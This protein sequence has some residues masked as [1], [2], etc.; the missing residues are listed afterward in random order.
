M[1]Y[2]LDVNI[3]NENYIPEKT[4]SNPNQKIYR[5]DL[6]VSNTKIYASYNSLYNHKKICHGVNRKSS[7]Y[8]AAIKPLKIDDKNVNFEDITTI[9]EDL[10]TFMCKP[11]GKYF[12][13][14]KNLRRHL[15]GVHDLEQFGTISEKSIQCEFC[16]MAFVQQSRLRRHMLKGK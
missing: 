11:C 4:N 16:D 9:D 1:D 15:S 5:C 10:N 12:E 6:C 2:Y 13:T 3:D 8:S 14:M 7:T